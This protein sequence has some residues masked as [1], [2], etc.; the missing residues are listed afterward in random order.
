M[1]QENPGRRFPTVG[2]G[3]GLAGTDQV[4]KEELQLAL[5]NRGLPLE[6][7]RYAITPTGL[8]YVLIH[9]DI[10]V[11]NVRD[12]R[13][14]VT[15]LVAN[16]LRL[17]LEE[18]KDR[19]SRTLAVTME[20]AGNGRAMLT[21]R[22]ISQPWLFDAIGTAEWRGTP[23]R[24]ILE[25]AGIRPEAVDYVFTGLDRG[26]EGGQVQNYQRSLSLKD[27]TRDE[28]LLAYE[29]NGRPLE[30]QHGFP[31]RLLVPGWYGMTSVKW[32]ERIEAVSKPFQGYQMIKAY[33]YAQSPEESGEPV[34][35]IR[36]RALMAPPGIPDFLTRGRLVEAGEVNLVGKAWAGRNQVT[37]VEVST[38]GGSAWKVAEL[39]DPLSPFAWQGWECK[40]Q[41]T[42][43]RYTLCVRA[44]DD[45]GN[46]QP[47]DQP[48]NQGGYSNNMVQRVAVIVE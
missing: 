8:H 24:G 40:W 15:G 34:S 37:R 10:P 35:L 30:P 5:R 26:V 33:R 22:R 23:L 20:C 44:S 43:G 29:M 18:I 1:E 48:W 3:S 21:P 9:Y 45:A 31:L 36:V 11:V 4:Y 47:L 7:L 42:P 13:L 12:W 14:E 46:V 17:S 25:D 41:A 6:A 32:L 19:P 16:A 39:E 2:D 38:D 27:A 28:V